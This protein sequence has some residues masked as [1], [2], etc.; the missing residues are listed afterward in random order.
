MKE[1]LAMLKNKN[2][3]FSLVEIIVA[4]GIIAMMAGLTIATVGAIGQTR[5]KSSMEKMKSMIESTRAYA[6]THG[7]NTYV[8]IIKTNAGV[9]I[10]EVSTAERLDDGTR[11][12]KVISSE[13]I[14]DKTLV[15]YYKLTGDTTEYQ[16]GARD[17]INVAD[18]ILQFTFTEKTGSFNGP[19]YIDYI[20]LKNSQKEY[21]MYFEHQTG[22]V[23]LDY[24]SGAKEI[25]ERIENGEQTLN[26]SSI[27]VELPRFVYKGQKTKEIVKIKY[28]G[29]TVQPELA[30]NSKY[31]KMSGVYRAKEIGTYN[32]VFSLK[33]VFNSQW[34]DGTISDYMLT[35][36]IVA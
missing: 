17:A 21:K 8:S 15:L 12:D 23:Y 14:D 5:M 31:A 24:E 10:I 9:Q 29:E 25:I 36:E 4:I 34:E 6:K 13:N 7:G 32:I 33:D 26:T 22:M 1:R 18:G 3:G 19:H 27:P 30:Y 35:W 16:L 2:K 20:R 28:T 11:N